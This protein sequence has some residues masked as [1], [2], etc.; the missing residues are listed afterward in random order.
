MERT[1]IVTVGAGIGH[2]YSDS[3]SEME[4]YGP[5]TRKT[6]ER[7]AERLNKIL[8]DPEDCE[9]PIAR[10]EPLSDMKPA[11]VLDLYLAGK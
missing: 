7:L 6:A 9:H 10:A 4:M 2:E 1:W 5:Y 3:H 8:F 11:D